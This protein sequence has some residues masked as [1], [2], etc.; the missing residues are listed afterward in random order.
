[1]YLR[2]TLVKNIGLD[3]S[4]VNCKV[5]YQINQKKFLNYNIKFKM[6]EKIQED[7]NAKKQISLFFK[8]KF[9]LSKKLF[10]IIKKYFS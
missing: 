6:N 4:G 9:R 10:L 2:H 3:G 1:M 5:D 8:D 7:L